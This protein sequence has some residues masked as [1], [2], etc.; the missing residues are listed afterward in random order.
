[1][2]F[3]VTIGGFQGKIWFFFCIIN[4][5][6]V[7]RGPQKSEKTFVKEGLT[8]DGA[9]AGIIMKNIMFVLFISIVSIVLI[10][11]LNHTT[12]LHTRLRIQVNEYFNLINRMRE[13]V[14][15]LLRGPTAADS[16]IKFCNKSAEKIFEKNSTSENQTL[17]VKDFSLPKF[18]PS[19]MVEG[20]LVQLSVQNR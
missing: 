15:V 14:I 3:Q 13:G 12:K 5:E 9:I 6:T 7:F 19:K 16:E 18:I 17:T 2:F 1:M 11:L 8:S 4:P 10:A 20:N